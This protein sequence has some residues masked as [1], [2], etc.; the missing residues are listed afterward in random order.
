MEYKAFPQFHKAIEERTVTGLVAIHGNVD[1]G[2]DRSWPGSFADVRDN[3]R[4]RAR[5]VWQHRTDE[6]PTAAINYLREVP[7]A[8]LPEAVLRFAPD[9]TGAVEVSRTYL[10]TPRGNEILAGIRSGAIEEMSYA[11]EIPPGGADIEEVDGRTIRNIRKVRVFDISDV[12]WGMNPA[13]VASKGLPGN[14]SL[15]PAYP[16][17]TRIMPTI[18]P[19]LV[20][21]GAG[22]VREAVLTYAYGIVFDA[23]PDMVHHWYI[24]S[25]LAFEAGVE[26][27]AEAMMK[28]GRS[29]ADEHRMALAAIDAYTNRYKALASL[30]AKEGR[31]L[32]GE[33]RKRIETAVEALAGAT[34]VLRGLLAA[35]EPQ[36]NEAQK[37][38]PAAIRREIAKYL[39]LQAQ[40]NGAIAV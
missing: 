26:D 32:S 7:R 6:P 4:M 38:D 20:G 11:Y 36:K 18:A 21:Q 2:G 35:T 27:G 22:E 12:L 25:E 17:G 16:V 37:A 40:L 28:Q 14:K 19:H 13:T 5:F 3:G 39:R 29:L 30:R 9:A 23:M 24:E 33:N 8:E 15:A 1:A 34:D 10:D 31:V